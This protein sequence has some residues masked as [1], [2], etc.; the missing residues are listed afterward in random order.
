M[1]E[2]INAKK[3]YKEVKKQAVEEDDKSIFAPKSDKSGR[4]KNKEA[5]N[6]EDVFREKKKQDKIA[7]KTGG[8]RMPDADNFKP[9]CEDEMDLIEEQAKKKNQRG[10]NPTLNPKSTKYFIDDSGFV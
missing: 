4:K 7:E 10:A 9:K 8:A 2:L 1:E 5:K 6:P 3:F